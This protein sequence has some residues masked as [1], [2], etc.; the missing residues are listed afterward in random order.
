MSKAKQQ[1]MNHT[2]DIGCV[3]EKWNIPTPASYLSHAYVIHLHSYTNNAI[4]PS[5]NNI[6]LFTCSKE[7]A[8]FHTLLVETMGFF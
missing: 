3:K 2:C 4:H 8:S 5:Y 1:E 7:N 6:S